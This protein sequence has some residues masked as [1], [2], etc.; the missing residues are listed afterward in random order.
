MARDGLYFLVPLLALAAVFAYAEWWVPVLVFLPLAV[1]VAFFFRDPRRTI[2]DDPGAIVS[3]ADGRVI[4]LEKGKE[5]TRV[6]IF[7]SVFDVHINRAP[8]GGVIIRQEYR[9]GRFLLAYD[10]RA[11]VDNEQLR[12]TIRG[13]REI[14]FSLI[15][16]LIARRIVSWKRQGDGVHR[17]DKI[18]LIRFGSRVDILLPPDCQV[19]VK[20]GDRVR[21]GASILGYWSQTL[22]RQGT[23]PG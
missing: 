16:G 19:L 14:S 3:P 20:K 1:F 23:T 12:L 22:E 8:I 18:G 15:A 10:D 6:S 2:P 5:G 21:G 9:P 7:L 13:D 11:S 17:G 4:R